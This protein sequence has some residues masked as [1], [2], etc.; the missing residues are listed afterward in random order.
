[1]RKPRGVLNTRRADQA[2]SHERWPVCDDLAP[3]V[4]HFWSVTWDLPKTEPFEAQTLPH[5]SVHVVLENG[6][7]EV[8]GVTTARFTRRLEGKGRVFGIKFRPAMFSAWLRKPMGTISNKVVGIRTVFGAA[9]VAFAKA[10]VSPST[11]EAF[12]R[13]TLPAR[14]ADLERTR[15]LVEAMATDRTLLRVEDV[16][17]RTGISL[18]PLQRLFHRYVGASPKWVI[19][20]YRLHEA[21]EQLKLPTANLVTLAHDLGYFD[22]AHFTR[23]FKAIIGASPGAFAKRFVSRSGR[24]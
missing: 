18:R 24:V 1:M 20:R 21:A 14:D 15:D 23:D 13:R 2:V 3:F 6:K 5:P 4:E 9:G 10:E 17:A 16:V 11:A 7:G 19:Q 8:A 12:L 22:Q